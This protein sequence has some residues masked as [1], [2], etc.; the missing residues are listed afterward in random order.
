MNNYVVGTTIKKL[1]KANGMTQKDLALKLDVSNKTISKWETAKGLPDITLLGPLARAL[2]ITVSELMSGDQVQNQN[3]S[4][5][6]LRSRIYVCPA[7]GNIIHT[8]GEAFIS[9]CGITLPA[10]TARDSHIIHCEKIENEY[11]VYI[12]HEMTKEHYISFIAYVSDNKF[13]MIK[14]YPEGNA[15]ARF[16]IRGHGMLYYYCNHHGLFKQKV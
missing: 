13:E 15:E 11:Y 9:C 7:C 5:N 4:A 3:L 16:F 14:L 1:R 6:M 12:D 10:L 2:N 8:T